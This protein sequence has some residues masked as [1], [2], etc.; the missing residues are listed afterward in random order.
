MHR[1]RVQVV[2]ACCLLL[3]APW[4]QA[5]LPQW[6]EPFP[7]SRLIQEQSLAAPDYR[8][9]LGRIIRING[10]IRTDRELRLEGTLERNTWQL[11]VGHGP[12]DG[13]RHFREQLQAHGADILFECNSRQCGAS[14]LWANDLFATAR[15]YGVDESQHYLAARA[16]SDHVIVYAI[17]RGNGRVFVNV[18]WV[19]AQG[20]GDASGSTWGRTLIEQGYAELPEW[21]QSPD[22]AVQRLAA[23]LNENPD[24]R[25]R[26]VMHKAGRDVELSLRQ[27]RELAQRLRDEVIAEG[28]PAQ[29]LD[30]FGVG[31]L[32]PSVLGNREQALIVI[33]RAEQ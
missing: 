26:L 21:P 10:Q 2:F 7:R 14:N 28:I 6:L 16:G 18:D 3:L 12:E 27:S 9:M 13:F 17:R 32:V 4:L 22:E 24:Y 5:A 29:R 30:A 25:V 20:R 23:L 8:V 11:P 15:L 31:P 19:V 1:T 33:L